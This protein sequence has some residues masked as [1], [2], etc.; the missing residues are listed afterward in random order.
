MSKKKDQ[1]NKEATLTLEE[2]MSMDFVSN[3]IID[4]MLSD[5]NKNIFEKA[6]LYE[7]THKNTKKLG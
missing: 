7:K 6:K 1:G 3:I 4:K 5:R 2:D